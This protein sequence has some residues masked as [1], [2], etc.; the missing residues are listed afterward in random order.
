MI[1][2]VVAVRLHRRADAPRGRFGPVRYRAPSKQTAVAIA[3]GAHPVPSRTPRWGRERGE[4]RSAARRFPSSLRGGE[5]EGVVVVEDGM[6]RRRRRNTDRER[7]SS[8]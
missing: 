2:V 7:A 6:P 1:V 8:T 5:E 3:I 4:E